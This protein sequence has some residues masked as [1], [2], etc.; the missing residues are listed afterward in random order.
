MK[1]ILSE[2]RIALVATVS[3]AVLLC[4]IYPV[5][6]WGIAQ[7]LFP[8]KANGSLITARGKDH[9]FRA[10]WPKFHRSE[11]LSSSSVCGRGHRL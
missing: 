2:L 8:H 10:S 5:V 9:R 3:L 11:I 1:D 7:G 4:G 6:V